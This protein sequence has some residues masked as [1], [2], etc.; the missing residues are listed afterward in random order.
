MKIDNLRGIT[1][2]LAAVGLFA[3]MDAGLKLL[4]A[5]YPPLQVAA[6]RGAASVPFVAAWVLLTT[7]P[8]TLVRIRWPLHLLRGALMVTMMASFA[9]ALRT[10]PLSTAYAI[11]FVAPL[12]ITALSVPVLGERV[13]PRRWLAI[14][15]GLAGVLIVLRPTG[16]GAL[17]LAGLAMLACATG[18]AIAAVTVRVLART[19]S[20]Q[21]MV[22]WMVTLLAIGAGALAAPH[23]QAVAASHWLL[24]A[25]VG[26]TGALG[27]YAVTEAFR[28]GEASVIAP[29]EYTALAWGLGF[30]LLLWQVLPDAITWIGAAVIVASGLYLIRR[31]RIVTV[32]ERREG[33][34]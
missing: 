5:H 16:E 33:D 22:F 18:Y 3:T 20:T 27:Q 15:V 7:G 28:H 25:G 10:L 23:W 26:L 17:T 6:L 11:F 8:G 14:G 9:Y 4:A 1:A 12:L 2:M 21:S 29:F 32:A 30:D 19:D 31:E 24:I 34:G 13:G